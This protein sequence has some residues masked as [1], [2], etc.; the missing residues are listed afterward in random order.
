MDATVE[1]GWRCRV[2]PRTRPGKHVVSA[3][4]RLSAGEHAGAGE[5]P[6]LSHYT[7]STRTTLLHARARAHTHTQFYTHAFSSRALTVTYAQMVIALAS[8]GGTAAIRASC[9]TSSENWEKGATNPPMHATIPVI[10][11]RRPTGSW[12]AWGTGVRQHQMV[13]HE[14]EEK[15]QR[16]FMD[17]RM[18]ASGV[19]AARASGRRQKCRP[20]DAAPRDAGPSPSGACASL[21]SDVCAS[22]RAIRAALYAKAGLRVSCSGAKSKARG[23]LDSGQPVDTLG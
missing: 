18:A 9:V 5:R 8:G 2:A 16:R 14:W 20:K 13:A 15:V 3:E 21:P 23:Q 1:P 17:H 22:L 7:H 11:R 12:R 4:S 10:R 6:V 19:Y